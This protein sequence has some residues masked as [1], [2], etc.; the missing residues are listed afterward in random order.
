[1]ALH[2]EASGCKLIRKQK[3]KLEI[4]TTL[5]KFKFVVSIKKIWRRDSEENLNYEI[6]TPN[7]VLMDPL[8]FNNYNDRGIEQF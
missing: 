5:S 1:M 4:S 6:E 8:S 3:G 7:Y 2:G